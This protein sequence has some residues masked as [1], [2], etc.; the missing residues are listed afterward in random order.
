MRDITR[1]LFKKIYFCNVIIGL[2]WKTSIID[3]YDTWIVAF[4]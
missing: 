1:F 2:Y 4:S 3:T